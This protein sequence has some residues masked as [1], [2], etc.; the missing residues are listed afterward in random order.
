MKLKNGI[1]F[2]FFNFLEEERNVFVERMKVR[3]SVGEARRRGRRWSLQ[4]RRAVNTVARTGRYLGGCAWMSASK[5][6]Q[7][8]HGSQQ[9]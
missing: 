9:F 8:S 6:E 5:G 1:F 2:Y 7:V 4:R 3:F